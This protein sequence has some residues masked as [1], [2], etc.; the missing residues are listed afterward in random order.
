MP[1]FSQKVPTNLNFNE[2]LITSYLCKYNYSR[3]KILIS[4]STLHDEHLDDVSKQ[5]EELHYLPIDT[6]ET[7]KET[8][9]K[10]YI[11]PENE[12]LNF[13]KEICNYFYCND[14]AITTDSELSIETAEA[15]PTAKDLN[16]I[17]HHL[18]Y[19]ETNILLFSRQNRISLNKKKSIFRINEQYDFTLVDGKEFYLFN[20]YITCVFINEDVYVANFRDFIEIFNYKQ[21]LKDHVE[22]VIKV[23]E[24][25]SIITNIEPFRDDIK[26]HR[27]FN[28]LTKVSKNPLEIKAYISK[29]KQKIQEISQKHDVRF[30][31]NFVNEN[32]EVED[33]EGIKIIIRI[34]SDRGGFDFDDAFITFP[35]KEKVE[36][37]ELSTT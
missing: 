7:E 36:K 13:H 6:F 31:F 29:Y 26:H 34:I 22:E 11:F 19:Q 3:K 14:E 37:K 28:S 35:I 10:V 21:Y 17:I 24:G 27:H 33:E 15:F 12:T 1:L 30:S 23:L 32:F 18:K 8:N 9:D 25:E 16:F 5:F 4:S 20:P 2:H